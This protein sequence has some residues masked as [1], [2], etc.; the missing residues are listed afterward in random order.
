M[1]AAPERGVFSRALNLIVEVV[2]RLCSDAHATVK[3]RIL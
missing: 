3:G 2:S 1:L